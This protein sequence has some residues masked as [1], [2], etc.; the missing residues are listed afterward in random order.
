MRGRLLLAKCGLLLGSAAVS[1]QPPQ[2]PPIPGYPGPIA[3][4]LP[5][6]G[7]PGA[8][9]PNFP[10][11]PGS[12]QP[13]NPLPPLRPTG[14]MSPQT[15]G[16][17][18]PAT[19]NPRPG[20]PLPPGSPNANP[21]AQPQEIPLPQRENK[22]PLKASDVTLKHVSG[23]WQVWAGQRMLR[24]FGDHEMD[25]RDAL[26]VFRDLHP[27]EWV[28]I[29]GPKP[30]VE[31]ALVNGRP[32]MTLEVPGADDSKHPQVTPPNQNGMIGPGG[33]AGPGITPVSINGMSGN[34]NAGGSA[35]GLPVT[36]A[37]AKFV[38]PIDLRTV[39]VE[40]VRGVWCLR[41][42]NNIHFNF[43][44]S[45]DD[46]DQAL[47]VVRRYGFNRV[48][49]VGAPN[50]LLTYF[51]V[52]PDNAATA[53][54]PFVQASLQAQIE[55]LNR[56][57]IPVPGIGYVGEMFHFD[58]R[59]VEARKDG[60]D[61]VV[62]AG[63]E[64]LGRYGQGEWAAREAARTISD[65]R[66]NDFCKLGSA[67]LTFFLVD[68]N[69]PTRVPYSVQGRRFDPSA[70]KVQQAGDHWSVTEN[71]RHLLDCASAN[72]GETLIRVVKHFGFDQVCHLGPTEKLGVSFM[73]KV[74]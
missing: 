23:A 60:S 67:G 30:I 64:V 53:K 8:N 33:M 6:P 7:Y 66:F 11:P 61:W 9:S 45:K 74:K 63:N 39:R 44:P 68:G 12:P 24:D 2:I 21:V 1:A 47:A 18:A 46:A 56:V 72:E 65:A 42:D 19:P 57:G 43:G 71:G 3:P 32:T 69:A 73:T 17:N 4:N 26:R 58:P 5:P 28:S 22:I 36:G 48:G 16:A 70:L 50:P 40:P 13:A 41:D 35:S 59:K 25:A 37:G 31:Y 49:I 52:G 34:M 55:A 14:P 15:Q 27:T 62:A 29:G 10:Q 20:L 38:V 51:F 54:G